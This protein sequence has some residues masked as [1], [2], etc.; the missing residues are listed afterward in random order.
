VQDGI[1]LLELSK[2]AYFFTHSE[3]Q[4]KVTQVRLFELN[5]EGSNSHPRRF[6]NHLIYLQSPGRIPPAFTKSWLPTVDNLRCA[7]Q[8]LVF[9]NWVQVPIEQGPV[10]WHFVEQ[11]R[12]SR[13]YLETEC[14]PSFMLTLACMF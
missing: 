12:T 1:R 6:A 13:V 10:E 4:A 7:K 11:T 3:I 2:K 14:E 8:S 9:S 5:M